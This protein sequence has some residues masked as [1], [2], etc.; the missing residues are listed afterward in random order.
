MSKIAQ[1]LNEHTLGDV[2]VNPELRREFSVDRSVLTIRPE[3]VVYPRTTGDI[4]KVTK[5]TYQLSGKGH[6]IGVVPRGKGM[7][8][9]GA[10]IGR[11]IVLDASRYMN[12]I[13]EFDAKQ[14]LIRVQ[15]GLSCNALNEAM[16]I[17]GYY[18][19]ALANSRDGTIGGALADGVTGDVGVDSSR[20]IDSAKELEIVLANGDAI[21]TRRYSK[22]EVSKKIAQTDFEGEIYRAVE[23][24]I[25]ENE[26]LINRI[27]QDAFDNG[28]YNSI[29]RVRQK[30]GSIDLTPLFV[31]SQGTLG[32][33]SEMIMQVDF[34]NEEKSV[35]AMA[36]SAQQSLRDM[37]EEIRKLSPEKAIVIDSKMISAA[38]S[39][40]YSHSLVKQARE[41]RRQIAGIILCVFTDFSERSR[42]R[43]VKKCMKAAESLNATAVI[44]GSDDES[45]AEICAVEGIIYGA[46]HASD[47][48]FVAPPLFTGAYVPS[49]RVG[50]L[51]GAIHKLEMQNEV[52]MPYYADI[53]RSIYNFYPQFKYRTVQERRRMLKVY[54]MFSGIVDT[55]GGSIVA[56]AGEGRVKSPFAMRNVSPEL[57]NLYTK[58][59][60]IF[61]P[62]KTL[63]PGV[64]Q[65]IELRE[66]VGALRQS[67]NHESV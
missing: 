54:D 26:D 41:S 58:I 57:I 18:M 20:I 43:K 30:D 38:C 55:Y 45:I 14:R 50:D 24:L 59:R 46:A 49:E 10:A 1:Y 19:P 67:Y 61:D 62:Q 53:N 25:E 33:V 17:Q 12:R 5:F 42:K 27:D 32:F 44:S 39:K 51:A 35:V 34:Y 65:S 37:F 29:A 31:G 11:G 63:N 56:A 9:T 16:K 47:S 48:D 23:A 3:I 21:Q 28:G 8:V 6:N 40:G 2:S 52:A 22:R 66:I 15:P 7:N 13:L 36:F 4:R 60:N 64:K